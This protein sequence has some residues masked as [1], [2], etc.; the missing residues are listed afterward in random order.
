MTAS[1]TSIQIA[2]V[3]GMVMAAYVATDG[4]DLEIMDDC[5]AAALATLRKELEG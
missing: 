4:S 3:E 2:I 1:E 5:I